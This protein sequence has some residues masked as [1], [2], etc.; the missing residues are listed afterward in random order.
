MDSRKAFIPSE[1]RQ[2]NK[3]EADC[4]SIELVECKGILTYSFNYCIICLSQNTI[5]S[6]ADETGRSE[7]ELWT[8]ADDIM[9]NM[10]HSFGLESTKVVGYLVLKC[11]MV[12]C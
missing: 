11:L 10:A 9:Q 5:K 4:K 7:Q 2:T 8:E 1:P 6:L 12:W 3:R